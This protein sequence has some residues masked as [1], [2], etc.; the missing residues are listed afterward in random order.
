MAT[1]TLPWWIEIQLVEERARRARA[2]GVISNFQA[3]LLTVEEL[4]D[5]LNRILAS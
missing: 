3:G 2:K 4:R 1:T 5:V